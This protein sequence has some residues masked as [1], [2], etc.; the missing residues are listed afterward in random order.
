MTETANQKGVYIDDCIILLNK[1]KF[2][3]YCTKLS[4]MTHNFKAK[5]KHATEEK[6]MDKVPVCI[7]KRTHLK[8]Y[9]I[10]RFYTR[11]HLSRGTENNGK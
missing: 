2:D 5:H 10:H 9:N 6:Y 11:Q 7:N 8:T 3:K 4:Q 1:F